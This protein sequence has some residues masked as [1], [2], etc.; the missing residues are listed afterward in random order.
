MAERSWRILTVANVPRDP[1]SGAAGTVFHTNV[2][3]RELGHTVDEIWDQDLGR[4]RIQHGNLHSL[5]EQPRLYRAAVMEAIVRKEYDIIQISQPQGWLAARELKARGFKGL[6]INRSH[7]LELRVDAVLPAWHRRLGVPESRFPRSLFTPLLRRM[8]QGQWTKAV[9]FS[10]G[11]VVTCQM[12]RE[13]LCQAVPVA[14]GKT[15]AIHHGVTREFSDKPVRA[16]NSN[17]LERMLYVGQHSFIK[18]YHVLT[19]VLNTILRKYPQLSCTY[20]TG[21][22]G[23]AEIRKMLVPEV[24]QQVD[25]LG[26]RPQEE[27]LPLYDSHGI[28]LFPSLFEGAGKASLEALARQMYVVASDTGAMRDYIQPTQAGALCPVGDSNAFVKAISQAIT[29]PEV[30]IAAAR[31]G[32]ELATGKTWLECARGL[33]VMYEQL[34]AARSSHGRSA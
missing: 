26:W 4:R 1:N 6:V 30:A 2:A 27:L 34:W 19:A 24:H 17:L 15:F 13:Y 12:D 11:I 18:G 22:A 10:D 16:L 5:L 21:V 33:C 7:G 31:R 28:F 25:L 29:D 23:H 20:V 32:R 14:S 8:L 3:L 9:Q